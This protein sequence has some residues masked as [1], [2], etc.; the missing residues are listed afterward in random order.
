MVPGVT[1]S[2]TWDARLGSPFVGSPRAIERV[3]FHI[4]HSKAEERSLFDKLARAADATWVIAPEFDNILETR[5]RIVEGLGK[6]L[7]GPGADAVALCG[8]KL[9]LA[10]RFV[11]RGIP[12]IPTRSFEWTRQDPNVTRFVDAVLVG[13][14]RFP[15][16]VKPRFGAG[17]QSTFLIANEAQLRDLSQRWDQEPMLESAIWQPYFAGSPVSVAVV[18]DGARDGYEPLP[19]AQ[20]CLSSDGR[21]QYLGGSLPVAG[22]LAASVRATA[23]AACRAVGGL[24]GYVGIDLLA[25]SASGKVVVV[26]INPRMTTSY[27]GYR[28]LIEAEPVTDVATPDLTTSGGWRLAQR[29]LGYATMS[30]HLRWRN[31]S[32]T[33]GANGEIV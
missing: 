3:Q 17:S 32:I 20:Q 1:V 22:E 24:K 27:L 13:I 19:V 25:D 28:R 8:D 2:S 10:T 14:T 18:C 23:V 26:E 5:C 16:V 7:A 29:I 15:I 9:A 21:F 11:E 12:T 33:F 4:A 6:P 31:E 30:P